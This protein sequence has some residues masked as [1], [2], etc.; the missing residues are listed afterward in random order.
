MVVPAVTVVSLPG[1]VSEGSASLTSEADV[2]SEGPT[3]NAGASGRDCDSREERIDVQKGVVCSEDCLSSRFEELDEDSDE[4]ADEVADAGAV[5]LVT[6]C[7]LTW[8][9]K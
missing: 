5:E 2:R 9:G 8:R 1:P 7:L 3:D 4:A 6:T